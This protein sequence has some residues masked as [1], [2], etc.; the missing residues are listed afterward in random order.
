L[1]GK[2][3]KRLELPPD[4]VVVSIIRGEK[5]V[6]PKGQ[7]VFTEGDEVLILTSV[8]SEKMLSELFRGPQG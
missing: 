2:E 7:S 6:F 4:C 8:A 5:V 3:I 1:I